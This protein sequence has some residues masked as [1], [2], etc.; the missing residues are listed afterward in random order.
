MTLDEPIQPSLRSATDSFPCLQPA[1]CYTNIHRKLFSPNNSF[2]K[3]RPEPRNGRSF[4][5]VFDKKTGSDGAGTR[6]RGKRRRCDFFLFFYDPG[7]GRARFSHEYATKAA[8]S[9]GAAFAKRRTGNSVPAR[10]SGEPATG[11]F[12]ARCPSGI[13]RRSRPSS[14]SNPAGHPSR[15]SRRQA[16]PT[17]GKPAR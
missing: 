6:I 9:R 13:R 5:R 2:E 8:P 17:A 4:F 12:R 16:D 3:N 1:L 10:L 7:K 15:T 14:P 11:A